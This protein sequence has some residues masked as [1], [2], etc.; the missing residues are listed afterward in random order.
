MN[1]LNEIIYLDIDK[2]IAFEVYNQKKLS[3]IIM[4]ASY[5]RKNFHYE[6]S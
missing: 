4:L 6:P 1:V 3:H 5:L 2:I